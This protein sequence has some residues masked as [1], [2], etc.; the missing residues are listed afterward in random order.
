MLRQRACLHSRGVA[1]ECVVNSLGCEIQA[2]EAHSRNQLLRS[3]TTL[4]ARVWQVHLC[5]ALKVWTNHVTGQLGRH[6]QLGVHC[7]ACMQDG[8]T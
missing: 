5:M 1:E 6:G 3:A 8:V 4:G 7:G 2:V